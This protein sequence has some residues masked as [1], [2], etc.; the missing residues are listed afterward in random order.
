MKRNKQQK[1]RIKIIQELHLNKSKQKILDKCVSEA[2]IDYKIIYLYKDYPYILNI[3]YNWE[4][5]SFAM[6]N[7]LTPYI[8]LVSNG[9]DRL[10]EAL[11][12]MYNI[13]NNNIKGV[14][15]NA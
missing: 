5:Y 6:C 3:I 2:I 15:I 9:S 14:D 12:K 11:E 4:K 13:L 8:K 1:F 7:R 10:R